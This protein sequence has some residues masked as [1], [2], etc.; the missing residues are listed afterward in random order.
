[1]V[2]QSL[3]QL[4]EVGEEPRFW[5]LHVIREYALERLEASA[6]SD[7]GQEAEALHRAHAA[8]MLALVEQGEPQLVGPE[9]PGWLDRLEREQDNLRAALGWARALAGAGHCRGVGP[10]RLR[11]AVHLVPYGAAR[12]SVRASQTFRRDDVRSGHSLRPRRRRR[13]TP[14]ARTPHTQSRPGHLH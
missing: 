6:R 2:E 7:S 13:G 12:V 10:G 11:G 1:L 4:R 3:L 14:T 8:Y 5:L 9:A